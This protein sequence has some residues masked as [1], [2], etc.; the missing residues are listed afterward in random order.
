[1]Q[2]LRGL[3]SLHQLGMLHGDFAERNIL[4]QDGEIRIIDFG[5][6][7]LDHECHCDMNF[8]P[9]E[10]KPDENK[11]GCSHLWDI[12]RYSMQIWGKRRCSRSLQLGGRI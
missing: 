5:Q 11:F 4:Q 1:L 3:G 7:T 8:C 2:I 9:G 12:C 10:S 6:S